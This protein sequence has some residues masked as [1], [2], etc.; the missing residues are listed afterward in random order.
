MSKSE[1]TIG[2]SKQTHELVK[3]QK[4]GGESFD[5]LLQKMAHQYEPEFSGG[6]ELDA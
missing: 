1:T 4:R 5:T 2:V 6:G 3:S